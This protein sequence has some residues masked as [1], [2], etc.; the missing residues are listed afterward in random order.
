MLSLTS[1]KH[2]DVR[3]SAKLLRENLME[4]LLLDRVL[5]LTSQYLRP[6]FDSHCVRGQLLVFLLYRGL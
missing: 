3:D 6:A 1:E 5:M 4:G 2:L